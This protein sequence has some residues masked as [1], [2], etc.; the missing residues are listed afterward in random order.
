M[1]LRFVP[2]S[3]KRLCCAVLVLSLLSAH[4]GNDLCELNVSISAAFSVVFLL[5]AC[6]VG[7]GRLAVSEWSVSVPC[8]CRVV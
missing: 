2:V 1:M 6:A 5:A 7:L 8:A 3:V 4:R